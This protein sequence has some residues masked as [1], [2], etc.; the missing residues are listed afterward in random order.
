MPLTDICSQCVTVRQTQEQFT[1]SVK[2]PPQTTGAGVQADRQATWT[3]DRFQV[4]GPSGKLLP[5]MV[6]MTAIWTDL[7]SEISGSTYGLPTL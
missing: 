7:R 4:P 3:G 6:G 5:A 2:A 1:R